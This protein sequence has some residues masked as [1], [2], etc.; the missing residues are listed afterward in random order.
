[1]AVEGSRRLMSCLSAE[2]PPQGGP[3]MSQ[4]RSTGQ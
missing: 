1:M 2:S 4:L 3:L